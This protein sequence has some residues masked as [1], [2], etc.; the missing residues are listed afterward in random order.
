MERMNGPP[1]LVHILFST[2]DDVIIRLV[3]ATLALLHASQI[4]VDP[5]ML[6]IIRRAMERAFLGAHLNIKK[7]GMPINYRVSKLSDPNYCT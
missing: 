6:P 1:V 2:L 5:N 4:W 3:R 7:S